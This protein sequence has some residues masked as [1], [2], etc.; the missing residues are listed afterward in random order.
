VLLIVLVVVRNV[1]AL[2]RWVGVPLVVGGLITLLPT[3]IYRSIITSV[4]SSGVLGTTPEIIKQEVINVI[5]R[6]ADLIFQPM[7]IQ[8]IIIMVVG[9]LL[10]AWMF[11]ASRKTTTQTSTAK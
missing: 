3:L 7:M 2:G 6:A 5:T 10:V 1:N 9:I 8:A 11:I 4:L